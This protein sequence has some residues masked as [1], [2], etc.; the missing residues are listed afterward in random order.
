MIIDGFPEWEAATPQWCI[1]EGR[2]RAGRGGGRRAVSVQ[3]GAASGRV[4]MQRTGPVPPRG[5][6]QL[7]QDPRAFLP[8]VF[9]DGEGFAL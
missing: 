9:G 6:P 2:R 1:Q 5:I 4:S 3:G 8:S 7:R